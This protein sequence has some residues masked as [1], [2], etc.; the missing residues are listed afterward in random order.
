MLSVGA[1]L[2]PHGPINQE[3]TRGLVQKAGSLT[4]VPY[5]VECGRHRL[6]HAVSLE[7]AIYGTTGL[8]AG[9]LVTPPPPESAV[10]AAAAIPPPA[11]TPRMMMGVCEGPP[12]PGAGGG[13]LGGVWGIG[14]AA[15]PGDGCNP[16]TP[17]ASA[18]TR[19]FCP[20]GKRYV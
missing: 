15:P 5:R 17:D 3:L 16:G 9:P 12:T 10:A 13:W 2:R 6:N 1:Q 18:W 8:A 11:A 4:G 7:P 19:V 20:V 14:V